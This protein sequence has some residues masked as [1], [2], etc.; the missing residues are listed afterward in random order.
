MFINFIFFIV[1]L[2]YFFHFNQLY[3]HMTVIGTVGYKPFIPQLAWAL[4]L[5]QLLL[6]L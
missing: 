6:S 4:A 2:K 1:M 3:G 5:A